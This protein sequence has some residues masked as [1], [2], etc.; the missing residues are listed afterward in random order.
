M[1]TTNIALTRNDVGLTDLNAGD[2]RQKAHIRASNTASKE[3]GCPEV[4]R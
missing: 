2:L 1:S 3:V 4:G